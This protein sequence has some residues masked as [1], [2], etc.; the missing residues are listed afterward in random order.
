MRPTSR[1][2]PA[3]VDGAA[4]LAD[5]EMPFEGPFTLLA[6]FA[7]ANAADA[8]ALCHTVFGRKLLNSNNVSRHGRSLLDMSWVGIADGLGIPYLRDIAIE[9]ALV[10]RAGRWTPY[11]AADNALRFCRSC[12][13]H[14]YQSAIFQL[15]GMERCPIHQEPLVTACPNC[16]S[17]S[18]RYAI[19]EP[20]FTAPFHC[21]N[22]M[23]PLA[24]SFDVEKWSDA[25]FR[26]AAYTHLTPIAKWIQGLAGTTL[27]WPGWPDWH[28]PLRWHC[29]EEERR[30][31]AFDVLLQVF[32]PPSEVTALRPGRHAPR[33]YLGA[34]EQMPVPTMYRSRKMPRQDVSV[35]H[36]RLYKAIR[37]YV[38]RC[39]HGCARVSIR[40]LPQ[41]VEIF[42]GDGAIQLDTKACPR[43]QAFA[44]WRTHF[45]AVQHDPHVLTL[46]PPV[47]QWPEGASIDAAAWA[48]YL[49]ASF[50][51]AVAAFDDWNEQARLLPD[52]GLYGLDRSKARELHSKFAPLLSPAILSSFPAVTTLTFTDKY[53]QLRILVAGPPST[54]SISD[55]ANQGLWC[56]CTG[57]G[58]VCVCNMHASPTNLISVGIANAEQR[59]PDSV[60][61]TYFVPMDQLRLPASLDGSLFKAE[62]DKRL[63]F[64]DANNDLEAISLWLEECQ[65]PRTRKAYRQQIEKVLLW[66]VAQRGIALSQ[67]TT[68]DV[69]AFD[70]F[71][72][73]PTPRDIWL[74]SQT[75]GAPRR[76]SPFSK[77][78][79]ARTQEHTFTVLSSLLQSWS[80]QAFILGNPCLKSR[81]GLKAERERMAGV[82]PPAKREAQVTMNEWGYL[83]HAAGSPLEN[84]TACVLL[85]LAYLGALK[86][87]EIGEIQLKNVRRMPSNRSGHDIWSIVIPS[88]KA[89]RQEVFL[90]ASLATLLGLLFPAAPNDY[91]AFV[92]NQPDTYLIDL[93]SPAPCA[94]RT[95]PLAPP[96]GQALLSWVRPVFRK[97]AEFASRA[98]DT[99]A[100]Q[101]LEVATLSWLSDA[102]EKHLDQKGKLGC[103][104][105]N[106]LGACKLC[107]AVMI[108]YLPERRGQ[109]AE[110]ID[111][112]LSELAA[113]LS[114]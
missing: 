103:E 14:G 101:R 84:T 66:C 40:P 10:S 98:G 31:A 62:R 79:S 61:L 86:A 106:A 75:Q 111:Q 8:S 23:A 85:N 13:M 30:R 112:A 5:W 83:V 32:P 57:W 64:I 47:L 92:A 28:F 90:M 69:N 73:D 1:A 52:A 43:A 53:G 99:A 74:P 70:D 113:A 38:R 80:S 51:A 26:H 55:K 16:R 107:P 97:A 41:V 29:S 60:N 11:I 4:W 44:L 35:D 3:P 27:K 96:N 7:W 65:N 59:Q 2:A 56:S 9:G 34:L 71:L 21:S 72:A 6:K 67:M 109:R 108:S 105:W 19:T 82:P 50:H 104:C 48:G 17:G 39:L 46:R 25:A 87:T 91:D 68:V 78:P 18:L 54:V 33:V 102:L 49:L 110:E 63:S 76:W 37:R 114:E 94:R 45:E 81:R 58:T 20:G 15:D 77:A 95:D 93:L 88:R 42:H 100:A 89:Q 36:V 24:G 22:C 12:L